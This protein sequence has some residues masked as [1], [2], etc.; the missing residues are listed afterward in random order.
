MKHLFIQQTNRA[1]RR[2]AA[3]KQ[4]LTVTLLIV[5]IVLGIGFIWSQ[6]MP[7]DPT[8]PRIVD[9]G[10]QCEKCDHQW[11]IT[12]DDLQQIKVDDAALKANP[13]RRHNQ[14]HCPQ[15]NQKH[16]GLSMLECPVCEK[17]FLH[18]KKQVRSADVIADDP[19]CPHCK[20]NLHEWHRENR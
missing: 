5:V 14:P 17:H 12:N 20:T 15:C 19:I 8:P 18:T 3:S 11:V 7:G 16:S 2:G 13:N 6:L 10:F 4:V 1:H 9:L